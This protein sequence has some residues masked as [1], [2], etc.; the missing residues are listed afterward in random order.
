MP[1]PSHN[2]TDG[3]KSAAFVQVSGTGVTANQ[4]VG[5]GKPNP[6]NYKLTLSLGGTSTCQLTPSVVDVNNVAIPTA[7]LALT[8]VATSVGGV[9]VYTGTITGGG[10]NAFVGYAFNVAGFVATPANNGSFVCTASTTTTITLANANAVAETHAATVT[11]MIGAAQYKSFNNPGT[12]GS[13]AWLKLS[14]FGSYNP[15]VASVSGSG[16]I[17]AI[18]VGQAIIEVAYPVFDNTLGNQAGEPINF[19]YTQVVVT[20]TP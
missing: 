3:L 11:G 18:A 15:N 2:P 12:T 4:S 9:A 6:G 5:A 16:L 13:P 17:T 14:N 19:I 7:S 8:S 1:N 10:A 20:V